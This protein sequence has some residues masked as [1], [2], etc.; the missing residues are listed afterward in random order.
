MTMASVSI[1]R[2][3]TSFQVRYRCGGRAYPLVHAGS[4]KTLREARLRR[5]LV[6]GELAAGRNPA[7][8][9]E[10]LSAPPTR[11]TFREWAEAY[12]TSRVDI[13]ELTLKNTDSHLKRL[14]GAFG[15]RD[16]Q[17]ITVG[18]VQE[19]V[20]QNADLS[21]S[22]F[23]P[24]IGTLRLLLDFA[25]VEP[26]PARDKR[27]KL[28]RVSVAEI[29]PP[30]AEQVEAILANVRPRWRLALRTLEQSGMRVGELASLEW[31]D[32][33]VA[34][35]RFRIRRGKTTSAAAGWPCLRG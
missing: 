1:R 15:D 5:D 23:R 25:G 26:N 34:G 30:T 31:R 35:S 20:G 8:A 2:R 6:A 32:V 9:L 16:P 10:V 3:E 21:P 17:T 33:D 27:V 19:W 11:R 22:S 18:D 14:N 4:F 24:Y 28:P 12:K 29:E 7:E 13:G